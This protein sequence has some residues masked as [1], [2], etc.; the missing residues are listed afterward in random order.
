M[1]KSLIVLILW[2]YTFTLILNL[3]LIYAL[4]I[5]FVRFL[6]CFSWLALV[7]KVY[8][9]IQIIAAIVLILLN[10]SS[11]STSIVVNL[12]KLLLIY[13]FWVIMLLCWV[14]LILIELSFWRKNVICI[15][16]VLGEKTLLNLLLMRRLWYCSLVIILNIYLILCDAILHQTIILVV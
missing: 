8:W 15:F 7:L 3:C 14:I 4:D 10:W 2:N 9:L 1:L 6:R 13:W 5:I 16:L 11:L 12:L